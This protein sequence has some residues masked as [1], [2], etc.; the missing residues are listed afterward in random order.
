MELM[1]CWTHI[2]ATDGRFSMRKAA[3]SV[4]QR[5]LSSG[6]YVSQGFKAN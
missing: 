6:D 2:T 5:E 4:G 3:V 1:W